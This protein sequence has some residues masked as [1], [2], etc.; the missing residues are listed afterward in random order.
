MHNNHEARNNESEENAKTHERL[1][2]LE[3]EL[4]ML[5]QLPS[6]QRYRGSAPT[7]E[8]V[9]EVNTGPSQETVQRENE[10]E[11]P[12]EEERARLIGE[13]EARVSE[14]MRRIREANER[15]RNEH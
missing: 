12:S 4:R 14:A 1:R 7:Q 6:V 11:L 3:E 2:E 13:I 9:R 15:I 10:P 5:E 8:F